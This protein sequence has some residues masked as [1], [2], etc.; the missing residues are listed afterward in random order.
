M[1]RKYALLCFR[2]AGL[3][4]LS[5]LFGC[6]SSAIELGQAETTALPQ[7]EGLSA[8]E[9][10]TLNS[11]EKVDDYPLYTMRYYADYEKRAYSLEDISWANA[12]PQTLS[13][14][15]WSC[16][17]FA[18]LGD[19]RNMFYGRNFDWEY[20]PAL[21]LH[22]DP[23]NGY[24]SAALVD[25]AY[26]GFGGEKAGALLDVPLQERQSLLMAPFLPFDG[27]NEQGLVIGMAA[28]PPGNMQPDPAKKTI[29]SLMV[30]RLILDE[31]RNVD[32]AIGIFEKYNIDMGDGPP[33]HY[34]I[35]DA[36]GRAVL[37]EFY[38]GEMLIIP[39]QEGWHQATNF[40][41]SAVGDPTG[42][43]WR[44]DQ[45]SQVFHDTRGYIVAQEA[46]ETL[47]GVSQPET[48]WSVVY[49]MSAG[50]IHIA[51]GRDYEDVHIIRFPLEK[52]N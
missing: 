32:E 12:S 6:R 48:Q 13:I 29:N 43:C 25:I 39:N 52:E 7:I 15:L 23:P 41:V 22:T 44:Y 33:I 27:L 28:V 35:A 3:F 37:V 20:S 45:L 24:A 21:L 38:Q 16:S 4:T 19:S 2:L 47:E 5:F 14:P 26:L 8:E 36:T 17:L 46:M 49:A 42:Q 40:L 30:I 34:L 10:A 51:M 50:E 18:A 31:A 9:V 11:I 1:W